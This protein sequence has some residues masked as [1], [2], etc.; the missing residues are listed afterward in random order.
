MPSGNNTW[1]AQYLKP[2]APFRPYY[3]TDRGEAYLCDTI[4]FLPHVRDAS[5]DLILTSP[6]FALKRKKEYGN[7]DED[8]Y[9]DWF[10]SFAPHLRRILKEDGSFVI[11]PVFWTSG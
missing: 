6:P 1:M 2:N 9:C 10:V 4:E 8:K 5:V 11:L 3:K 7:E